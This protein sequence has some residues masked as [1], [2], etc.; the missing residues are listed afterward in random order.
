MNKGIIS[1]NT[2]S[3]ACAIIDLLKLADTRLVSLKLQTFNLHSTIQ[4]LKFLNI[5]IRY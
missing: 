3:Q 1:L 4:L 2:N 5:K